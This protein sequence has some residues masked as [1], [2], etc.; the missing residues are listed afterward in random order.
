MGHK[1]KIF[2]GNCELCKKAISIVEVGK[3]K[4]CEL[5][6]IDVSEDKNKELI[7]IFKINAVPTII[8]DN[9]IKIVGIPEFPWFCGEEFY[10][11]L[12]SHFPILKP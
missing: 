1:I 3:C 10:K 11:M 6:V 7:K 12:K 5:E 2:S 9:E 8:I 4:D